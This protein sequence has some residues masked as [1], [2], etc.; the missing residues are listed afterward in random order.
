M[1]STGSPIAPYEQRDNG[2]SDDWAAQI[3]D[4][5]ESV[6]GNV[7]DKTTGPLLTIARAVVYGTFGGVVAIAVMILAV[8]AFVRLLDDILPNSV[9]GEHHIWFVYLVLG[10]IFCIAGA[11]LWRLRRVREETTADRR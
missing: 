8:I 2:A 11:I 1:V 6:V 4:S 10:L 7:R 5:I 3:A 9:F